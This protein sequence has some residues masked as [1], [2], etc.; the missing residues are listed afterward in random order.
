[1]ICQETALFPHSL[2]MDWPGSC[3]LIVCG[4]NDILLAPALRP[5]EA[6]QRLF[7]PVETLTRKNTE[8]LKYETIWRKFSL[9]LPRPQTL[10]QS[11]LRSSTL[12]EPPNNYSNLKIPGE[13]WTTAQVNN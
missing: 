13:M 6:F 8:L 10:G 4:R 9:S 2:A 12:T 3:L 5:Q 7:S 11:H 1:M